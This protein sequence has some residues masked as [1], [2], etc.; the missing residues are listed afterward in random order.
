MQFW[1]LLH[2][3]L[4]VELF[5]RNSLWTD[6]ACSKNKSVH[7]VQCS[8]FRAWNYLVLSA[9]TSINI[10]S[11]LTF[12]L[13]RRG[14]CPEPLPVT[15]QADCSTTS[16]F[17]ENSST[18]ATRSCA[19]NCEAVVVVSTRRSYNTPREEVQQWLNAWA[20]WSP[21]LIQVNILPGHSKISRQEFRQ[22]W[23]Q[24]LPIY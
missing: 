15:W 7:N 20:R 12:G 9:N 5:Q 11:L 18:W 8:H 4:W 14:H 13:N 19:S 3:H 6:E 16:W 17:S 10:A 2:Q 22:L 21:D 1:E 23:Q 24:P